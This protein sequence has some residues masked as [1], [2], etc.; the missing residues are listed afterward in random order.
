[1]AAQ[2]GGPSK[3]PPVAATLEFI[4]DKFN[5]IYDAPEWYGDGN[6]GIL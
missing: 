4:N 1:M 5:I 2:H 3:A 6:T